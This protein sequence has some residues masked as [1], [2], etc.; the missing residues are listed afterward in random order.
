MDFSD[1]GE[2]YQWKFLDIVDRLVVAFIISGSVFEISVDL[3]CQFMG[4]LCYLPLVTC[5]RS[6][7]STSESRS[8]FK[9]EDAFL[10][11]NYGFVHL[12]KWFNRNWSVNNSTMIHW[13]IICDFLVNDGFIY[14]RGIRDWN[15]ALCIGPKK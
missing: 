7:R 14:W 4:S 11:P 5:L 10:F 9:L 3:H 2:N 6:Y 13:T 15:C 1:C 8:L 12:W